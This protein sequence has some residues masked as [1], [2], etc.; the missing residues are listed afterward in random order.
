MFIFFLTM[1]AVTLLTIQGGIPEENMT[2]ITA[3]SLNWS[4]YEV[5]LQGNSTP[6]LIT[7]NTINYLGE[8]SM[9]IAKNV[10]HWAYS[11]PDVISGTTLLWIIL[12]IMLAPVLYPL[13]LITVS[14]TLIIVEWYKLRKEKK[15][16]S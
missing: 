9:L 15:L 2:A 7:E 10:V 8:N 1:L 5:H 16:K 11:N 14:I 3:S 4:N 13:F 6:F 12:L